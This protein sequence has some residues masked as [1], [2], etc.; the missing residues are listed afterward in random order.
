MRFARIWLTLGMVAVTATAGLRVSAASGRQEA[1]AVGDAAAL[2][3]F[4]AAIK[5]YMALRQRLRSEITGPVAN[6]T[7]VELNS[8]SDRLAAGIQR[9]R[10]GARVGTIFATPIAGVVKRRVDEVVRHD[11][12][13]PILAN[14]DDEEV[15][16]KTPAIHLRF[17][18]ASQMAT[19][20]PSLLAALPPLPKDLEYRI[21]GTSLV[22]RDVD[23]ALIL[24]YIPN[25]VP[26]KP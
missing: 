2:A 1:A 19:M 17:P 14:I 12:L 9:A 21:V 4:E 3:Q 11:N 6:S 8:A 13:G 10:A 24:D 15:T 18:A 5:D 23:A 20:P 7:A 16:V 26:R 25:A 22:L